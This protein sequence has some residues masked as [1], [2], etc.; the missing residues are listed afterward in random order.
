M[1][2]KADKVMKTRVVFSPEHYERVHGRRP[3]GYG[4]WAFEVAP[5]VWDTIKHAKGVTRYLEFRESES[6]RNGE[7]WLIV[8][9]MPQ[10]FRDARRTVMQCIKIYAKGIGVTFV[11]VKP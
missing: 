4:Q 2:S 7:E 6:V 8:V 3:R 9:R 11:D 10:S 1:K 5:N